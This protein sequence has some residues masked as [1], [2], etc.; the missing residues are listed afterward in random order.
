M[1]EHNKTSYTATSGTEPR[2]P[3]E[4]EYAFASMSVE[5]RAD[6]IDR[7][8]HLSAVTSYNNKEAALKAKVAAATEVSLAGNAWYQA[9]QAGTLNQRVTVQ[10]G[11]TTVEQLNQKTDTRNGAYAMPPRALIDQVPVTVGGIQL[12]PK[13]AQEM[14]ARGEISEDDYAH[15]VDVAMAPYGYGSFR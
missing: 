1:N 9:K 14:M 10:N 11:R 12:G 3:T 2:Q 5:Q 4:Q 7:L 13:Q 8:K 6:H 15:A